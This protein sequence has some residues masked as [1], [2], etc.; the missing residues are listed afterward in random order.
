MSDSAELTRVS[1]KIKTL[2][3]EFLLKVGEK[4]RF[5]MHDLQEYVSK[6]TSIA[7]DSPSR[8]LRDLKSKK[9]IKYRL[10]SRANSLYEF[11]GF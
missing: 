1:N 9:V 6:N 2:I 11:C 3:I 8:V 7:P 5:H 10:I 4:N